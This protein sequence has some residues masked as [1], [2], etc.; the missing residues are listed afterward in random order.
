MASV[1]KEIA[2]ARLVPHPAAP[3]SA[4]RGVDAVL[5][6]RADGGWLVEFVVDHGGA[7]ALPEPAAAARVD[8]LWR[9]TCFELFVT[10]PAGGYREFNLSPSTEWAAYRF[11]GYREGMADLPLSAPPAT[12]PEPGPTVYAQ[13]SILPPDAIPASAGV[14]IAL[15]AVIEEA[16]GAKSYWAVTHPRE[17]PDFHHDACFALQL[18]AAG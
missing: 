12:A 16:G 8:E 11:T 13:V 1:P 2:S 7:L 15:T 6:R 9:T 4:V 18:P 14:R 17:K 3:P 5:L 10:D